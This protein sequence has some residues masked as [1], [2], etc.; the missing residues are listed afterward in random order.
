[1]GVRCAR[2]PRTHHGN[3]KDQSHRLVSTP[4]ILPAETRDSQVG[5]EEKLSSKG[6]FDTRTVSHI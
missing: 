6:N 3:T 5:K 4:P 2:A 1:M